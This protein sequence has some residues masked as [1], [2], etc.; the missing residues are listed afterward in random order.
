[1]PEYTLNP[2]FVQSVKPASKP[3]RY[4]DGNGLYLLVRPAVRTS[5]KFWVQRITVHGR[6]REFGL[7]TIEKVS[8]KEARQ[9]ALE[10]RKIARAGGDP[11]APRAGSPPTFADALEA[12]IEIYQP[13]WKGGATL[14]N[15]WRS[16]L[17]RNA[18]PLIGGIPVDAIT[19]ADV[20][21]V[22]APIWTTKPHAARQVR[23]RIDVIMKWA[24]AQG[25]R[26]DNPAAHVIGTALPRVTV[27]SRPQRALPYESVSAAITKV[28]TSGCSVSIR[29]AFEFQVLCAVRPSE[30][31]LARWDD[32]E[33]Q[34][35]TWTIPAAGMKAGKA[36]RVP[37]SD[38]AMAVLRKAA[39]IRQGD[40]VF[41]SPATG[42][43]YGR[44][45]LRQVIAS[46]G[47]DAVPHGF[48]S[49]FRDWA[50]ER[51]NTPREVME[52]AL[53]HSLRSAV[54]AAYARTDLFERR[55]RLMQD[56]ADYLADAWSAT[57][58]HRES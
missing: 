4:R 39:A 17:R 40:W 34:T 3:K 22:L 49:S 54:E 52:A 10:N 26:T 56:W 45:W 23:R 44:D 27:R 16:S 11:Q 15:T 12:V 31:R 33:L 51:T 1:M 29:L 41:P 19:D 7:G 9:I 20:M 36:H 46:L 6:E 55:R 14:A 53:A 32:I 42:R 47:I 13:N 50:G 28:R 8:L 30:A 18:F 48:R 35:A 37:L 5:G 24:I 57:P 58:S 38:R 2:A 21:A 25:Y 43:P